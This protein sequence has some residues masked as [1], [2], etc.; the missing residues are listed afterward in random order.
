MGIGAGHVEEHGEGEAASGDGDGE[1]VAWKSEEELSIGPGCGEDRFAGS[2]GKSMERDLSAEFGGD[3]GD[4]VTIALG[5]S[6]GKDD[7]VGGLKGEVNMMP[8]LLAIIGYTMDGKEFDPRFALEKVLEEGSVAIANLPWL[9]R[10]PGFDEFITCVEDD[11]TE[12]LI[13]REVGW[14]EGHEGNGDGGSD[15]GAGGDEDRSGSGVFAFSTDV[16]TDLPRES[17]G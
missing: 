16:F 9:R 5:D 13:D 6:A 7:G 15:R 4:E 8:K 17:A 1:R 11:N 10:G 14:C 2:D 12:S 3:F